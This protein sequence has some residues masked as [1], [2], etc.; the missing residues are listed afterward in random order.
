MQPLSILRGLFKE[1]KYQ[2]TFDKTVCEH[3]SLQRIPEA[4]SWMPLIRMHVLRKLLEGELSTFEINRK[5]TA[6]NQYLII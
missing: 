4:M 6:K 3:P 2:T 5:K 1:K